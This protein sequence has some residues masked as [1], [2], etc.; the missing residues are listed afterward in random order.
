MTLEVVDCFSDLLVVIWKLEVCRDF[1]I[2]L[3]A[4]VLAI[5]EGDLGGM[6]VQG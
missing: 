1:E 6:M 4:A 2:R 5:V 3:R